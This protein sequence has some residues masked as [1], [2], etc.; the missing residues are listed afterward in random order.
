[1]RVS[2]IGNASFTFEFRIRNKRSNAIVAKGYTT[3]CAID[4]SY[5]PMRVPG[6]YAIT[7]R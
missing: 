3:H 5:Q 1:M 7:V 4:G 2:R 6:E